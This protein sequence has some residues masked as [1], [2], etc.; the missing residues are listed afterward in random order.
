MS[1][2]LEEAVGGMSKKATQ[3]RPAPAW[4]VLRSLRTRA[5]SHETRVLVTV[6][7]YVRTKGRSSNVRRR[8]EADIKYSGRGFPLLTH[9]KRQ[10]WT[11]AA[12]KGSTVTVYLL[13]VAVS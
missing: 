4:R 10:R 11:R 8:W 3:P 7:P 12:D 1:D 5:K 6:S 13:T 2:R 9:S